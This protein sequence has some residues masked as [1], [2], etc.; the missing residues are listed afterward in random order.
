MADFQV[1]RPLYGPLIVGAPGALV[2]SVLG[3]RKRITP[4]PGATTE[5][6]E[7]ARPHIKILLRE[8]PKA[9]SVWFWG[10]YRST[11]RCHVQCQQANPDHWELCECGCLG[12]YHGGNDEWGA[13]WKQVGD[14]L[15]VSLGVIRV[16]WYL[17]K[18]GM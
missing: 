14:G 18:V 8:L 13:G 15:L 16:Q 3:S 17:E 5:R 9:G 2:R 11:D 10:D 7:V 6:Y 1:H 4:V 12:A